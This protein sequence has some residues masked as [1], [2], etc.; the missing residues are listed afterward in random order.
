MEKV[1]IIIPVYNVEKYIKRCVNSIIEQSYKNFEIILINDG[2]KDNSLKICQ[3]I[4]K[5]NKN[6]D[7]KL[8]NQENSGPS[9]TRNRGIE[10]SSGE[11]ILFIDSD[12]YISEEVLENLVK[13]IKENKNIQPRIN[14]KSFNDNKVFEDD[15]ELL[16][17][18][19]S[20][21]DL[22]KNIL[23][24]KY[25]GSVC[26][27]LFIRE[28]IINKELRFNEKLHFME[29][30]V[31]LFE[32]L[33]EI[34]EVYIVKGYY[35]YYLNE[36]SITKNKIN[37]VKNIKSFITS[38]NYINEITKKEYNSEIQNKKII[39]IEKELAKLTNYKDL[40]LV[41]NNKEFIN[42]ILEIIN[43]EK[44]KKQINS[45]IYIMIIKLLKNKNIITLYIYFNLRK[46]LKKIKRG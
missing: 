44:N 43:Q 30:A 21:K 12:D 27:A 10:E 31:F 38:L 5:E 11:Y 39:I 13:K 2:S 9:K 23:T 3:E 16:E 6:I 7:I 34:D 41:I 17:N 14:F 32:Y 37:V 4:V 42:I 24:G 45:I 18:N 15:N 46:I 22:E 1:S 33:K 36:S 29:D 26:G 19:I 8:I 20:V 25:L 28:K 35:Y 40:K